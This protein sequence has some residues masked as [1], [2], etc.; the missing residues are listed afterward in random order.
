[1]QHAWERQDMEAECRSEYLKDETVWKVWEGRRE[2]NIK[3]D[4]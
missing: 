2:E 3:M 1:M 4:R